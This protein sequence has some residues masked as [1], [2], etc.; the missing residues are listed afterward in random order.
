MDRREAT[1][2]R[3]E[4]TFAEEAKAAG[5]GKK[6]AGLV[7]GGDSTFADAFA[8]QTRTD[9]FQKRLKM[10]ADGRVLASAFCRRC[11]SEVR[12]VT[13]PDG[14]TKLRLTCPAEHRS[15]HLKDIVYAVAEGPAPAV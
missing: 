8:I 4:A 10:V 13:A 1:R 9:A 7:A 3:L 11:G 12:A 5:K 15:K 6:A 14:R 2:V